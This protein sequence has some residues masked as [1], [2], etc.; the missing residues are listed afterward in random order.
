MLR[1]ARVVSPAHVRARSRAWFWASAVAVCIA[2]FALGTAGGS[3]ALWNSTRVIAASIDQGQVEFSAGVVGRAATAATD[4]SHS[5]DV[6]LSADD[7]RSLLDD[8]AIAVPI[9][10]RSLSQGSRGL[11]YGAALPSPGP[12]TIFGASRVW[13][14]SV[15]SPSECV[16]GGDPSGDLTTVSSTP[17]SADYSNSTIAQVE[18][19]CVH[20]V[21]GPMFDEGPFSAGAAFSGSSVG[22]AVAAE[23][24]DSLEVT[25]ALQPSDEPPYV[26]AFAFETFRKGQ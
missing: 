6:T 12:D 2:V 18:Y 16:I 26:I 24:E 22:G 23:A 14:E 8:G 7:A 11:R 4:Q 25:T 21:R 20:A 10:V 19:V 9:E 3:V 5:A 17:V 15:S 13:L 1:S